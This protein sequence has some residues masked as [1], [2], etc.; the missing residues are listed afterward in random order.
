MTVIRCSTILDSKN[1]LINDDVVTPEKA[2]ETFDKCLKDGLLIYPLVTGRG[3]WC[4][5]SNV[6]HGGKLPKGITRWRA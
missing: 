6:N 5:T 1:Y 3:E 2:Q 4:A